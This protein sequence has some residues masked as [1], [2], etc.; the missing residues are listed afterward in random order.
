MKKNLLILAPVLIQSSVSIF[1]NVCA[2]TFSIGSGLIQKTEIEEIE[3]LV[4]SYLYREERQLQ[5]TCR[6]AMS[7][8][9]PTISPSTQII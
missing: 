4:T 8:P 3:N 7:I 9:R 2:I 6:T 1:I 5:P